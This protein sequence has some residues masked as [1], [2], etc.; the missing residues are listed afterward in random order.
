[1]QGKGDFKSCN[2]DEVIEEIRDS[3]IILPI[4]PKLFCYRDAFFEIVCVS[5]RMVLG[6]S[7]SVVAKLSPTVRQVDFALDWIHIQSG[8]ALYR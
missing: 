1:M 5:P 3:N 6:L 4:L 2:I 7:R 8:K